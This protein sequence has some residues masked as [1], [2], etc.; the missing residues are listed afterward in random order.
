VAIS[1]T[2]RLHVRARSQMRAAG[3]VLLAPNEARA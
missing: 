1:L 2:V 3:A